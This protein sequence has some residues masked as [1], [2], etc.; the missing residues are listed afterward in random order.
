MGITPAIMQG[1]S[2]F[3]ERAYCTPFFAFRGLTK[4][5]VAYNGSTDAINALEQQHKWSE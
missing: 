5:E 4:F 2:N 3:G 1:C